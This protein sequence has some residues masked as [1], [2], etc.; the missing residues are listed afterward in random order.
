M[1]SLFK[2]G[3][4]DKRGMQQSSRNFPKFPPEYF[5]VLNTNMFVINNKKIK[6]IAKNAS[7]NTNSFV[8][9]NF[10]EKYPVE[11]ESMT[12]RQKIGAKEESKQDWIN[13]N[14]LSGSDMIAYFTKGGKIKV[15][16][17]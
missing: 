10:N 13:S 7:D 14:K 5:S 3:K 15:I 1:H 17:N 6:E 11:I 9:G 4:V 16:T 8:I 2:D 12:R